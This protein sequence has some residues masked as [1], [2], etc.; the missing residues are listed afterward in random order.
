MARR[1]LLSTAIISGAKVIIADE[2]TPGLDPAVMEE[3][4]KS[5]RELADSGC[6]VM[7]ITHDIDAALTIADDIAVFYAGTTVEIAPAKNF[8]GKGE[9]LKIGRATCRERVED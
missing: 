5:F 8:S 7:L 3:A 4:L 2:P 1:T 6:A 9:A